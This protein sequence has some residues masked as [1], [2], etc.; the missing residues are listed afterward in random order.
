MVEVEL[1]IEPL[2]A[3]ELVDEFKVGATGEEL[4][5]DF[6]FDDAQ[7]LKEEFQ[8]GVFIL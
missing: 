2:L 3:G 6:I 5:C 7:N 8:I 1:D 4:G